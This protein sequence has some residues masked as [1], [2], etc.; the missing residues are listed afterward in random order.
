MLVFLDSEGEPVQEFSAILVDEDK[1]KIV[2]VFHHHVRY[3]VNGDSQFIIDNDSFSRQHVHGLNLDF[4]STH[5]LESECDLIEL[6]HKWL[7]NHYP[8][9]GI[10]AHA[11]HKERQLLSLPIIIDVGLKSWA[12]RDFLSSHALALAR[13]MNCTSVKGVSCKDAHS[14]FIG[15]KPKNV[16]APTSGDIVKMN[17]SHH[18]SLYDCFECFLHYVYEK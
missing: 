12:E 10:L 14:S 4:L 1:K 16:H 6:F 7:S 13:K 8:I 3:P 11:P 9:D 15:W 18:C 2:D 17:F 5:G